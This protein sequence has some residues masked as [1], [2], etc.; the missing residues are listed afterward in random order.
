M[1]SKWEILT[2]FEITVA[3]NKWSICLSFYSERGRGKLFC[4]FGEVWVGGSA[5]KPEK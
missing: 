3:N 5:Y 1:C 2:H 4:A